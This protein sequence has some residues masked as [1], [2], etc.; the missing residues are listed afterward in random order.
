MNA[1]ID[2][3]M[4]IDDCS[5]GLI[6][7]Q[8][9]QARLYISTDLPTLFQAKPQSLRSRLLPIYPTLLT[10]IQ[11]VTSLGSRHIIILFVEPS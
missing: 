5:L 6:D 7:I 10:D 9:S 3:L 11:R 2:L 8:Q 4:F 1:I